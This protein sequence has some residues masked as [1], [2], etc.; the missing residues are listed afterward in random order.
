MD[1]ELNGISGCEVGGAPQDLIKTALGEQSENEGLNGKS[2]SSDEVDQQKV[3]SQQEKPIHPLGDRW[4]E[5]FENKTGESPVKPWFELSKSDKSKVMSGLKDLQKEIEKKEKQEAINRRK[6]HVDSLIDDGSLSPCVREFMESMTN[7]LPS[8]YSLDHETGKVIH[9]E[10]KSSQSGESYP[11]DTVVCSPLAVTAITYSED[12]REGGILVE[13]ITRGG[14]V[15]KWSYPQSILAQD[16]KAIAESLQ[17]Q[18][19]PYLP[20]DSAGKRLFMELLQSSE[21]SKSIMF[22]EK[23]GWTPSGSF[24]FHDHVV[25]DEEV[26]FQA[27]NSHHKPPLIKGTVKDWNEKVGKYCIG[28]PTLVLGAG[29]G[30]SSPLLGLLGGSGVTFHLIGES[31]SGKTLSI[32]VCCTVTGFGKGLWNV[33]ENSV[34]S[35]FEALNHIGATLDELH[36]STVKS[37]ALITYLLGNGRGKGRANKDGTPQR[38]RSFALNALSTGELS[39]DDHLA[40]G[41]VTVSGGQSVRF[42][43]GVSDVFKYRCF[44]TIHEFNEPSEFAKHIEAVTGIGGDTFTPECAGA[45]GVAF[46]EY[47]AT[48]F[49]GNTKKLAEVT[50]RIETH[51][52][53]LTPE[54]AE[55][56]VIRMAYSLALVIVSLEIAIKAGIIDWKI[57]EPFEQIGKWWSECV[58]ATRGGTKSTE[59]EKAIEAIRDFLDLKGHLHF[60]QLGVGEAETPMSI[61]REQYGYVE[62]KNGETTYYVTGAGFKKMC[63]GFNPKNTAKALHEDG[64]L[65]VSESRLSKGAYQNQK[66]VMGKTKE[67]YCIKGNF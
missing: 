13:W 42:I 28:N 7:H 56:Q 54:G 50:R 26:I 61:Q 64:L 48:N 63:V 38:V 51:A 16:F 40:K 55:S 58:L 66:K 45:V 17:R 30:L 9:T 21:P 57:K 31:S 67:Y 44:E 15:A 36:Q 32:G 39:L 12:E 20:H 33:T 60:A 1:N 5:A 14:N 6:N 46:I 18:R 65:E 59:K 3:Y 52:K 11:I 29:V 27:M 10:W 8:G 41:G 53:A 19:I 49:V 34:E 25:G 43:Q 47:L 35:M 24:V 4:R 23:T 62:T 2:N 22:T 37:A